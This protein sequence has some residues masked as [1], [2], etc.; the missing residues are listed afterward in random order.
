[1]N[2]G[3]MSNPSLFL[4]IR[5]NR[6]PT[7]LPPFGHRAPARGAPPMTEAG[8]A[9]IGALHHFFEEL[10]IAG[11]IRVSARADTQVR[12]YEMYL[13]PCLILCPLSRRG[14]SKA[15]RRGARNPSFRT[16]I[17]NP[18]LHSGFHGASARADT[19]VRPYEMQRLVLFLAPCPAVAGARRAGGG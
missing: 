7:A 15:G 1:M 2:R 9:P 18:C 11:A 10:Q 13:L 5:L 3:F 14:G 6:A 12:P 19:Q 4:F 8:P 16:P 17:R